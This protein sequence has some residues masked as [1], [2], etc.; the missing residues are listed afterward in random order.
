MGIV[1]HCP[2]S[3]TG[4]IDHGLVRLRAAGVVIC[5]WFER[6]IEVLGVACLQGT[7]GHGM[8]RLAVM[9]RDA[10]IGD[11]LR[12]GM[13]EA[14][15]QFM[16]RVGKRIEQFQLLQVVEKGIERLGAV[17]EPLQ[18]PVRDIPTKQGSSLEQPLG[19]V[20]ETI[21]PCH[22]DSLDGLRH[23][24]RVV[25]RLLHRNPRQL[26]Q[27]ERIAFGFGKESVRSWEGSARPARSLTAWTILRLSGGESGRKAS[28]DTMDF[29]IQGGR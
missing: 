23:H 16:R 22:E 2:L 5:Q 8:E 6:G 15:D 28:C 1:I 13:F 27:E 29:S 24:K 14:I 17:P 3:L 18:K 11:V 21:N 20:S 12:Q 10:L 26:F 4:E 25:L 7:T 9:R 19:G